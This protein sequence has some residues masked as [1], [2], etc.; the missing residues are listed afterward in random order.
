MLIMHDG[1]DKIVEIIYMYHF[2]GITIPD[3]IN[4]GIDTSVA[5]TL[6]QNL[7]PSMRG[8]T[9][10]YFGKKYQILEDDEGKYKNVIYKYIEHIKENTDGLDG[11][12]FDL[13][14][15]KLLED[16][17]EILGL[18]VI[19]K[20]NI[21]IESVE[22]K[23]FK[24]IESAKFTLGDITYILGGN[25]SGKSSIL[26]AMYTAIS[27]VQAAKWYGKDTIPESKLWYMPTGDF[28][29]LGH[30]KSWGSA[31]SE[32]VGFISFKG[33]V[34]KNSE[35]ENFENQ[36]PK[37]DITLYRAVNSNL[38]TR[39][40]LSSSFGTVITD[41]N[42]LYSIYA[43]GVS[44]IPLYEEKC[45]EASVFRKA[46]GGEANYV[47]RN[48]LHLLSKEHKLNSL[49]KYIKD[50][51]EDDVSIEVKYDG[52]KD[53]NVYV[54]ISRDGS[55]YI[56]LEMWGTGML[57]VIQIFAYVLLF[58]PS[59][60]ILDEPDSH[61]H[62]S[63]QK[64]LNRALEKI[65]TSLRCKV[66]VATHSRHLLVDPPKNSSMV[67]MANGKVVSQS[68]DDVADALETMGAFDTFDPKK[69]YEYL[70][71]SE[72]KDMKLLKNIF[73]NLFPK[74]KENVYYYSTEGCGEINT[75]KLKH[76]LRMF[77][78]LNSKSEKI[79]KVI[80]HQDRDYRDNNMIEKFKEDLNRLS[81]A[82]VKVYIFV[83]QGND[84]ESY[85]ISKEH[86]YSVYPE[87]TSCE[88]EY[89]SFVENLRKSE[90]Y[91]KKIA[92]TMVW[93]NNGLRR[94]IISKKYDEKSQKYIQDMNSLNSLKDNYILKIKSGDFIHGKTE[95]KRI[96]DFLVG[97]GLE[98]QKL[99]DSIP[100]TLVQEIKSLLNENE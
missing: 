38:G 61:I 1:V 64:E 14:E 90:K 9:R 70:V 77:S 36:E 97:R 96:K 48:I 40:V 31:N 75:G 26:Q 56:P 89:N 87:L 67:W 5:T 28:S 73:I 74:S 44:G 35:Q 39:T 95:Y 76:A 57:Q 82:Y 58:N 93:S 99:V 65:S 66:I 43:P 12:G 21:Q 37:C 34:R 30:E 71:V 52:I 88:N 2:Q 60:L 15:E 3:I 41:P 81:E 79:T 72:D 23:N 46:A 29:N 62:P 20:S 6:K 51:F 69:Y 98:S 4:T 10:N 83:T 7:L 94:D 8:K 91:I 45:S 53:P 50:I 25:N 86:L 19:K 42:T 100:D 32:D 78:R 16:I 54:S 24:K 18:D 13:L 63:G 33:K 68:M 49:E 84:L 55:K 27:S 22:I 92:S 47:L 85:Y 80:I 59:L 17:P 11:V